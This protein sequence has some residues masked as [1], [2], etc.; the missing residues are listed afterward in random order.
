MEPV[1]AAVTVGDAATVTADEADG[2]LGVPE[3]PEGALAHPDATTAIVV[4]ATHTP[5]R[6]LIR[7]PDPSGPYLD[8]ENLG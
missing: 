3:G 8:A 2:C 7:T 1:G 5:D 4:A 6:N